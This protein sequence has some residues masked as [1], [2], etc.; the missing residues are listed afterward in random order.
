MPFSRVQHPLHF[1][2]VKDLWFIEQAQYEIGTYGTD[3]SDNLKLSS[4]G[5]MMEK[6]TQEF[7]RNVSLKCL[8]NRWLY[9]MNKYQNCVTLKNQAGEYYNKFEGALVSLIHAYCNVIKRRELWEDLET[10]SN[11]NFVDHANILESTRKGYNF[12][13]CNGQAGVDRILCF[14]NRGL[15]NSDRVESLNIKLAIKEW[16]KTNISS[17]SGQ[18]SPASQPTVNSEAKM[19][20]TAPLQH[21]DLLKKLFDGLSATGDFVWS[22]GMASVPSFTQKIECV[23]LP[24]DMNIDDT[25]VPHAR[26]D[27]PW[28]GEVIPSY[29]PPISPRREP[30]PGSTSNTPVSQVGVR[31]QSKGKR[32]AVAV[33]PVEPTDLDQYLISAFTAQGASHTS[34]S[35]DDTS[36]EVV[37]VL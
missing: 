27:Y 30:T 29:D 34:G 4:I 24:H 3:E 17:N 7:K 21:R 37:Q 14:L 32:S 28:E 25:Q 20:K 19:N 10:F 9:L 36:A 13:W 31:T 11:L 6:G 12:T 5:N 16:S 33:Q 35:N 2:Y 23:P 18:I 1:D 26:I 8:R 15:F 22:S